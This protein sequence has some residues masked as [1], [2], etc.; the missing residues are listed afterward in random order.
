MATEPQAANGLRC[1][2]MNATSP[3]PSAGTMLCVPLMV[4]SVELTLAQAAVAAEQGA[5]LVE[6]RLDLFTDDFDAVTDL[7]QRLPL[8]CIVTCRPTW[9]G[10]Q[11]D[12]DEQTRISLLEHAGLGSR[13]PAYID[14]ERKAFEASANLRQKVKLVVDHPSQTRA[15]STGLILSSHDFEKRPADL[16]RQLLSMAEE[17]AARVIKFAWRARSL[18]DNVQAFEMLRQRLK[19]TIALCMDEAGLPSRVLAK[20]FGALLTFAAVEQDQGT[21]PGQPTV[22]ELKTLYRFDQIQP[23]TK[24]YGV[25][26][27]PVGHSLSP[28]IHNA[29]FDAANVNAVYLP[30]PIPPEYEHFKATVGEWLDYAPLQF[31]GASV[32]IPH[33]QNLMRFV[34]ERGGEIEPLARKIGA[35]NTLARRED[36]S[37]YACNTDYAAVLDSVCDRLDIGRDGLAGKRVAVLGA[38]G[39]ARAIVAGFADC[40][41]KVTICNRTLERARQLADDLAELGEIDVQPLAEA[42]RAEVDIYVNGTSVGMH[43]HVDATPLPDLTIAP[44]RQVVVFDTIYNPLET[45]LLR[46]A[47]EAG[48]LTI[49]GTQM[50]VYQGAAQF[51]LWTKMD[52]PLQVFERAML[53]QLQTS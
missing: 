12:G 16:D 1:P 43:P 6:L 18:R 28:H 3:T 17:P 37:L 53:E 4:H 36:G 26:G 9:E 11:Y 10:G 32:T 8:P 29:G 25:I 23:D 48:C 20:K 40:G 44:Q 19:P 46:E 39:V 34:E 30:L 51:K 13:Q 49:P 35:A 42:G 50:F 14:I 15:V 45:R 21:A 41:A 31:E 5:D 7:I 33:K 38:G 22:R 24:V 2:V 52:A 27:H 47:K